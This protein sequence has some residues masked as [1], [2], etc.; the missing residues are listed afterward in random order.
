MQNETLLN[1]T[2]PKVD[3]LRKRFPIFSEIPTY[4]ERRDDSIYREWEAKLTK[5][6]LDH[7]HAKKLLGRWTEWARAHGYDVG[8]L[9]DTRAFLFVPNKSD[10]PST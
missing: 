4:I 2:G 9:D 10:M 3:A 6:Y 1:S 7:E 8:I 5:L